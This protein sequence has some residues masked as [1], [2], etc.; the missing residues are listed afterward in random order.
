MALQICCTCGYTFR[1][2]DDDALWIKAQA[3]I[4]DSHPEMIG[5]VQRED[6]LAQAELV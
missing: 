1:A 4:K 6:I 2:E 5:M 3:H